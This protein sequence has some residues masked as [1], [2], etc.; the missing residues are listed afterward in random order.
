MYVNVCVHCSDS[1]LTSL[2]Q[3]KTTFT[4]DYHGIG[5]KIY[6]NGSGILYFSFV[7][8]WGQGF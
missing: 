2:R 6:S 3:L 7:S 1:S 5:E 4:W 8:P